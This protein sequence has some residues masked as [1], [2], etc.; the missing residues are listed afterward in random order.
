MTE[1]IIDLKRELECK[2]NFYYQ[3]RFISGKSKEELR[4]KEAEIRQLALQYLSMT[5]QPY[6]ISVSR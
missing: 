3:Q 4:Y 1:N 2:V 6:T 5:G